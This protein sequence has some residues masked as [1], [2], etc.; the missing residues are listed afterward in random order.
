MDGRLY[1]TDVS[2]NLSKSRGTKNGTNIKNRF[3]QIY[4]MCL[5]IPR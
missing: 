2:V 1:A 5:S 3:D 4:I